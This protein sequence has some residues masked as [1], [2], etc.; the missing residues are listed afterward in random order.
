VLAALL[1]PALLAGCSGSEPVTERTPDAFGWVAD[2]EQSSDYQYEDGVLRAGSLTMTLEDG[3]R[4]TVLPSTSRLGGT[5]LAMVPPGGWAQPCWVHV[6]LSPD[7]STALWLTAFDVDAV[8][9]GWSDV[10]PTESGALPLNGRVAINRNY[11]R[12]HDGFLVLSDGTVLPFDRTKVKVVCQG[13]RPSIDTM[14]T[15]LGEEGLLLVVVDAETG[16][17]TELDCLLRD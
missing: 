4:F 7:R 13:G 15:G 2:W 1:A 16:A 17:V 8:L 12:E 9:A 11:L 10:A 5:C 14:L 6:G 3:T